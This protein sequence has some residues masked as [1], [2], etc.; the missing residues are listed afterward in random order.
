LLKWN[1]V[2]GESPLLTK[3]CFRMTDDPAAI[4]WMIN[5][6][7]PPNQDASLACNPAPTLTA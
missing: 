7:P 1:F 4:G 6:R 3:R 5:K 2:P